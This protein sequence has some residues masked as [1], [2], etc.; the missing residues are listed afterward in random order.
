MCTNHCRP[1]AVYSWPLGLIEYRTFARGRV[2]QSNWL[3]YSNCTHRTRDKVCPWRTVST[4]VQGL[5]HNL[6]EARF[7]FSGAVVGR[8][9]VVDVTECLFENTARKGSILHERRRRV[10]SFCHGELLF[11]LI[12][13]LRNLS[14]F[15]LN[16]LDHILL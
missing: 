5:W 13:S 4:T 9:P 12:I 11:E 14:L 10:E 1:L 3:R 7:L 15:Y 16:C 6:D 8:T 2:D